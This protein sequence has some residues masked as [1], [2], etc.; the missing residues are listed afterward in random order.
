[1]ASSPQSQDISF[2]CTTHDP[3]GDLSNCKLDCEEPL[4]GDPN[5]EAGR[6]VKHGLSRHTSPLSALKGPTS[7]VD[8][9]GVSPAPTLLVDA[10]SEGILSR[11]GARDWSVTLVQG[12]AS[13][14]LD[15]NGEIDD[16]SSAQALRDQAE[17]DQQHVREALSPW[18]G[19]MLGGPCM[20]ARHLIKSNSSERAY[21]SSVRS[22]PAK[23]DASLPVEQSSGTNPKHEAIDR[24]RGDLPPSTTLV[25][26][27]QTMV[28][29]AGFVN[30]S[31]ETSIELYESGR[32]H[33]AYR[34]S[35]SNA[36]RVPT[37][38]IMRIPN[39]RGLRHQTTNNATVRKHLQLRLRGVPIPGISWTHADF[40]AV[41]RAYTV[42]REAPGRRLDACYS[43][44]DF[45]QRMAIV[46]QVASILAEVWSL[47]FT[48]IGPLHARTRFIRDVRVGWYA[49]SGRSTRGVGDELR[50]SPPATIREFIEQRLWQGTSISLDFVERF[51]AVTWRMPFESQYSSL[52]ALGHPNL[53]PHVRLCKQ[54]V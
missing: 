31:K 41:G 42:E 37:V 54:R 23:G 34:V 40:P 52:N 29:K 4:S 33:E 11:G 10:D 25:G 49:D 9:I 14:A 17:S 7:Q 51:I 16:K 35:I 13:L 50:S 46:D 2:P 39:H 44:F 20:V 43:E 38:L 36:Q 21:C 27:I 3:H 30:S 48:A 1:M 32:Q 53:L 24:D 19:R 47:H 15:E 6:T 22:L 18:R 45:D 5:L 28:V 12:L 26:G 8:A